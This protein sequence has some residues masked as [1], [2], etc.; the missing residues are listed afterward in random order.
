MYNGEGKV[1]SEIQRSPITLM[2]FK[3]DPSDLF[4][5][6]FSLLAFFQY[7]FKLAFKA[8]LIL[9][10]RQL[11]SPYQPCVLIQLVF[12]FV[13]CYLFDTMPQIY[14]SYFIVMETIVLKCI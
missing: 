13:C 5:F 7:P 2:F 11:L 14:A 10:Q 1:G 6:C 12:L 8:E 4:K 3:Y 9:L